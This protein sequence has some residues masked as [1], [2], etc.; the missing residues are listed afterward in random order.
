MRCR[1]G[2][3]AADRHFARI[4]E[5]PKVSNFLEVVEVDHTRADVEVLDDETGAKLGRPW[6]TIALDRATRI[7]VGIY[8]HFD[9]P[10][11]T[12]V[13]RVLHDVM[14]TKD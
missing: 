11:L 7:P 8:V 12:A 2:D 9:G 6:K 13:M 10:C 4:G 3:E 14:Q 5:G 1:L